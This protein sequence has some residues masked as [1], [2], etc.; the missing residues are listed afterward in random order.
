MLL[1]VLAAVGV[2]TV[3]AVGGTGAS[4][5]RDD[6]SPAEPVQAEADGQ[7]DLARYAELLTAAAE[8]G[9]AEAM[10]LLSNAY[11]FG[12]G[13]EPSLDLSR[14]WLFKAAEGGNRQAEET[15]RLLQTQGIS[16]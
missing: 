1:I 10:Y 16:Q 14:E 5:R 7:D 12:L 11:S 2:W 3:S 4:M 8:Q 6:R 9:E 13:V 15:V